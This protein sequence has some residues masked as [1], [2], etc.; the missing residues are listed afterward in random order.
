MQVSYIYIERVIYLKEKNHFKA[1]LLDYTFIDK[2][3]L[4]N[5]QIL[6]ASRIANELI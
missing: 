3:L 2:M 6:A 4:L 5:N 1:A